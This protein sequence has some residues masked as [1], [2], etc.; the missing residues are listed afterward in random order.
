MHIH[1]YFIYIYIY[2]Y[3]IY[4]FICICVHTIYICILSDIRIYLY[5][6]IY[7]F[8]LAGVVVFGCSAFTMPWGGG[9]PVCCNGT[10]PGLPGTA[11]GVAQL[12]VGFVWR[13]DHW[14]DATISLLPRGPNLKPDEAEVLVSVDLGQMI[15]A[16]ASGVLG[17]NC[18]EP[19]Y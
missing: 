5:I 18:G 16:G 19:F 9:S 2:I 13:G 6:D 15:I 14:Y 1:I 3:N 4:L 17:G 11:L 12:S 10:V 7:I 8:S